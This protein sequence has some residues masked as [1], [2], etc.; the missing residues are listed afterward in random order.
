MAAGLYSADFQSIQLAAIDA[1][2][3]GNIQDAGVYNYRAGSQSRQL[4]RG[5]LVLATQAKSKSIEMARLPIGVIPLMC[6]LCSDTSLSTASITIGSSLSAAKYRA[7]ATFTTVG[8]WVPFML[9]GPTIM[10]PL[11]A[12]TTIVVPGVAE[13][14]W[15]TNDATAAFPA[16]GNLELIFECIIP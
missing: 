1:G 16:A 15:I 10:L 7:N 4:F 11:V 14:I 9:P 3:G 8:Q 13:S 5:S 12:P 6:W 2:L